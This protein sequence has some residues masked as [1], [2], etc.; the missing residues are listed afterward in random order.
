MY[1]P[2]LMYHDLSQS[3]TPISI[4]PATFAWQMKW[5]FENQFRV[6]S[7][8]SLVQLLGK[9]TPLPPRAV[10][11]TFDDG[12]DSFCQHAFPILVQYQF[13]ATL[14]L[15]SGYCGRTNDWPSQP[16]SIPKRQLMN[17]QQISELDRHGIE[18]GA[19]T[20]THPRLD[21][22]DYDVAADEIIVSKQQIED[23]LGHTVAH[24][25]YPYGAYNDAVSQLV[26]SIF[27]GVCTTE[28]G[29]VQT[30]DDPL[31]LKRIEALYVN[32]PFLFHWQWQEH[33][34]LYLK[35]RKYLRALRAK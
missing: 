2:I 28:V 27:T 1:V 18:F 11:I 8:G 10:V 33:F 26:R 9:G 15:V 6:L 19:H 34:D 23:R 22:L 25:A 3:R 13:P 12:F 5:L 31:Q 30:G 17:W 16:T 4:T 14:F 35:M 20:V 24:F 7:L 21:R 29:R 32:R